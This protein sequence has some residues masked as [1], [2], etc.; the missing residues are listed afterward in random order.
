MMNCLLPVLLL[1]PTLAITLTA[2]T[3][4]QLT[5]ADVKPIFQRRCAG[6]HTGPHAQKGLDLSTYAGIIGGNKS[7]KILIPSKPTQSRILK[8]MKGTAKP[9]MPPIAPRATSA[10]ISTI[11]EWIKQGAKK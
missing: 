4:A 11:Y 10:E 2:P 8:L 5:Y 1:V 3:K 6:C 9:I 7:G